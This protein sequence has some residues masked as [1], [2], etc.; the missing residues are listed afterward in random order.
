MDGQLL[1]LSNRKRKDPRFQHIL[2]ELSGNSLLHLADALVPR[3]LPGASAQPAL[4]KA[5]SVLWQRWGIRGAMLGAAI[6][7]G[8]WLGSH[9]VWWALFAALP[10]VTIALGFAAHRQL[11]WAIEGDVLAVRWGIFRLHRAWMPKDRIQA[12][13]WTANPLDRWSVGHW[14]SRAILSY[15]HEVLYKTDFSMAVNPRS[16]QILM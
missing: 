8:G 15:V 5:S 7:A 1:V 14:I 9:S 2:C 13:E 16:A 3:V 11:G 10:I 4:T 6:G 12:V